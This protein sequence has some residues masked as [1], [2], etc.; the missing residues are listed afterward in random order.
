MAHLGELLVEDA[1]PVAAHDALEQVRRRDPGRAAGG[2]EFAWR[3]VGGESSWRRA[4]A[5][6]CVLDEGVD[7]VVS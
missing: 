3:A 1:V 4:G 7:V 5:R 6:T 2:E